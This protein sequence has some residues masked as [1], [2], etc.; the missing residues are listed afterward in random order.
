MKP[1]TTDLKIL[2]L[3]QEDAKQTIK[4]IAGKLGLTTTPVHE[5]IKRMEREGLIKGYSAILDRR[6]VGLPLLAFCNVRLENHKT[7]YIE[8]FQQDVRHLEEVTECYHIAGLFD[9][10][11]KIIVPDMDTYQHFVSQKLASIDNIGRVQSFFVMTD[12][13]DD[14]V[15]P[16]KTESV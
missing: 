8:K 10:L 7:A 15:F 12:V 11:L 4:E 3:L 9:Y 6:Q 13:K 14:P 5:R 1:D 2:R 16:I